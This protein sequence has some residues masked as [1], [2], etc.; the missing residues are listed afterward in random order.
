MNS[1]LPIKVIFNNLQVVLTKINVMSIG[2]RVKKNILYYQNSK[3]DLPFVASSQNTYWCAKCLGKQRQTI[4][5]MCFF[6]N[7]MNLV[8]QTII[9]FLLHPTDCTW[10]N[11]KSLF[12]KRWSLLSASIFQQTWNDPF[13]RKKNKCKSSWAHIEFIIFCR[14]NRLHNI[15]QH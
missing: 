2:V 14:D 12:S 4:S 8:P 9:C 13:D 7:D 1:F 15:S 3:N 10:Y 11:I 6:L 5:Q